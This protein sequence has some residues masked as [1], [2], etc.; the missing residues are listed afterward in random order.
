[1]EVHQRLHCQVAVFSCRPNS[2]DF[3][4]SNVGVDYAG[5]LYVK[6][7]YL[8]TEQMFKAHISLYTCMSSRAIHLDLVPDASTTAFIR[9][10]KR[11]I[12]RRGIP[13]LV[14]SDNAKTFKSAELKN[15]VTSRGMKWRYNVPRAPWWGGFFERM[16]RSVKRC[17]K[18]TLRNAR[19]TYEELLTLLIQIEGVLNSRPLTYVCED[20]GE[21]LTPSHLV[22]GRRLL[23]PPTE[24]LVKDPQYKNSQEDLLKRERHLRTVLQHFWKRWQKDYLT[25]LREHHSPRRQKDPVINVGDVVLVHE[26]KVSRLNWSIGKVDKLI[27]GADGKVRAA[28]VKT[29]GQR[30]SPIVLKRPVQKLFPVELSVE[31]NSDV[32]ISFVEHAE[33]ENIRN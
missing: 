28:V 3:A 1:M 22:V 13:S 29:I 26:D 19:L 2:D 20:G 6:D 4:F 14:L 32:P 27:V 30:G 10:F 15:F 8:Q 12:G 11:F 5:P 31:K 7:I 24:F 21:P 16:V 18:K 23:S 33:L 25:Q 17:L 9:C